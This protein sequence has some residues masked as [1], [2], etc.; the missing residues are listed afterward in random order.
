MPSDC[1]KYTCT[2]FGVDCSSRFPVRA[3]TKKTDKQTD[4]QTRL[5]AIPCTPA[6]MLASVM[7]I[8]TCE[9]WLHRSECQQCLPCHSTGVTGVT[10]DY[11]SGVIGLN[12]SFSHAATDSSYDIYIKSLIINK[13]KQHS[14]RSSVR[15]IES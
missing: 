7:M 2:K 10:R 6:A 15:V 14:E 1:Y 3:R 12:F 13:C 9:W 4:R 11:W 8:N 5:N